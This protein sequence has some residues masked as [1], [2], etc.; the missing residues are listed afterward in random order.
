M[1]DLETALGVVDSLIKIK[2]CKDLDVAL[3]LVDSLIKS[4]SGRDIV[5]SGEI[6]D[7]LLD[8]RIHLM[9]ITEKDKIQE[10]EGGITS[11]G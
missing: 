3:S 5:P 7:A 10:Q 1:K 6:T 11:N 9:V 4:C 8:L 2:S